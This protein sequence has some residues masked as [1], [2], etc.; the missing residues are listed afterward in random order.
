VLL[1]ALPMIARADDPPALPAPPPPRLVL[2]VRLGLEAAFGNPEQPEIIGADMADYAP[3]TV[4]VALSALAQFRSGFELGGGVAI[5]PGFERAATET[6]R[7]D[8]RARALVVRTGLEL[9][10]HFRPNARFDPWLGAGL[11]A[12]I[13][14]Y[15]ASVGQVCAS[16][17]DC[18]RVVGVSTR[19]WALPEVSVSLGLDYGSDPWRVG[20]VLRLG[21]GAFARV[22]RSYTFDDPELEPTSERDSYEL[23][24]ARAWHGHVF[25]GVRGSF[26]R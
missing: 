13:L 26:R 22:H 23:E 25:V 4:P 17:G 14:R 8:G 2:A 10:R 1:F 20:P 9:A 11:S 16:N 21:G 15:T 7:A 6:P 19:Y 3:L 5:A 12:E 18:Y 24:D